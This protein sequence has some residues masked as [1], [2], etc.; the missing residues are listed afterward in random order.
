LARAG[1]S[2]AS[3]EAALTLMMDFAVGATATSIQFRQ[4]LDAPAADVEAVRAYVIDSAKPWPAWS[5]HI[6]S[7]LVGSDPNRIREQT[8]DAAIDALLNGVASLA[9][10]SR[11]SGSDGPPKR[12]RP[13]TH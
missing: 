13:S 2:G 6:N 8:F 11:S 3:L 5:T 1:L 7:H 9:Q 10:T 4:W 12:H